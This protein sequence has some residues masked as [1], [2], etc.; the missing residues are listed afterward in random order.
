MHTPMKLKVDE[1]K[2]GISYSERVAY[3]LN[4]EGV[5]EEVFVSERSV[6]DGKLLSVHIMDDGD[7]SLVELPRETSSGA[8]RVWVHKDR[9]EF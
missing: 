2:P 3:I 9:V 6:V 7:T 4:S 1:I 8:W 5:R